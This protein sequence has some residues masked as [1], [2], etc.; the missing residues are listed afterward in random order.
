MGALALLSGMTLLPAAVA[1]AGDIFG[2]I[3]VSGFALEELISLTLAPAM[4]AAMLLL[5]ARESSPQ[6]A[7]RVGRVYAP[8]S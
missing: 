4:L 3:V 8:R 1:L 2:A 6:R 5:I 7:G